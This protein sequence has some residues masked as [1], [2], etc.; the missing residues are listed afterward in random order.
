MPIV[1]RT[2]ADVELAR[3]DWAGLKGVDDR[4]ISEHARLDPDTAPL[5]TDEELARA[6][7]VQPPAASAD[8][9]G[10]RRRLGL[11]QEALAARFG[12]SV[13][14]LRNYEQGHRTLSGPASVL[15][16]VIAREPDAV[17]RA[18]SK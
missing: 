10:I 13:E 7:L 16:R 6:R 9:K 2:R 3:V 15:L 8:V 12:F 18:L 11:S 14:T 4:A 17:I 1:R 5:F